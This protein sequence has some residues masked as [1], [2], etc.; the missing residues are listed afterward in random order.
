MADKILLVDDETNILLS[1]RR[2]LKNDFEVVTCSKPAEAI[3]MISSSGPFA[4]VVSDFRM[5]EMDGNQLLSIISQSSPNIIR[6]MLTGFV[7]IKVAI[8]A[9]NQGRVFR[10]LT[11]PIAPDLLKKTI[12]DAVRQYQLITAESMLLDKTLKGSI[13]ILID[14]L[15]VVNPL[16]FSL[17]TKI[18][19]LSSR[20]ARRVGTEKVYEVEIAA[21][22]SQIGCVSVPQEIL[23]KRFSG[24]KLEPPEEE[25][26][27]SHPDTGRSLI[28]NIPRL[29]HISEAISYQYKNYDG[30]DGIK[31]LKSF[32]NI[33]FSARILKVLNDYEYF[34]RS[35]KSPKE[36]IQA[37]TENASHYDPIIFAALKAEIVS[38]DEQYTLKIIPILEL[39]PGMIVAQNFKDNQGNL[40]ISKGN[41]ITDAI[42][43]RLISYFK[44]HKIEEFMKVYVISVSV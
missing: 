16:A 1:Y 33:P 27:Y 24:I 44:M 22:L 6:I 32:D 4:V 36:A 40:L 42:K 38:G 26:F 7:D 43:Y 9:V 14:I 11:K 41:E 5:P 20:I 8:D 15:S 21:L 34:V 3:G 2:I 10:F 25:L 39:L 28:N 18:R 19:D 29:E 17:A 23:E 31:N 12:I 37:M 30:S 13:K 35:N